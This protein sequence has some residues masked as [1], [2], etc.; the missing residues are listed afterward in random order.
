MSHSAPTSSR[1]G[2]P[3]PSLLDRAIAAVAPGYAR[4]RMEERGALAASGFYGLPSG[5]GYVGA[6]TRE[7]SMREWY[8]SI[9]S[10]SA[11]DVTLGDLPALRDACSDLARNNPLARAAKRVNMRDVVG[12]GLWPQPRIDREFLGMTEDEERAFVEGARRWWTYFAE[13]L[14][15]PCD[16]TGQHNFRGVQSQVEAGRWERGDV[17]AVRRWMPRPGALLATKVQV[18]EADRIS[19]PDDAQDTPECTAGVQRDPLTGV[20]TGYWISNQHPRKRWSTVP[21]KWEFV[22]AR[23]EQTGMPLA[24]LVYDAERPEQSRGVPE[25]APVIEAIH[26]LGEYGRGEVGAA[27]ADAFAVFAYTS[28]DLDD[29]EGGGPEEGGGAGEDEMGAIPL[30]A[31]T[32]MKLRPG[33]DFKSRAPSRP[34]TAF[35]AFTTSFSRFVG[36]ALGIPYEILLHHFT[37]SYSASR[38]AM[39]T[40]WRA[41]LVR[42]TL[43]AERLCQPFYALVIAECVARGYLAAPGF[44]TDPLRRAAYLECVWQGDVMPEIDQLKAALAAEKRIRIPLST[45]EEETLAATGGDYERNMRQRA[46]EETLRAALNLP[47][48]DPADAAV[49]NAAVAASLADT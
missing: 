48:M 27:V 9:A 14:E 19:N 35:E 5:G 47:P 46:K 29:T 49:G 25:L 7:P 42:R 28:T 8:K 17:L 11:D 20:P 45:V 40:F 4:R 41:V 13:N 44:F 34:N 22:P 1:P 31:M 15:H 6:R 26:Q 16:S 3:P 2:T 37:A 21:R 30:R 36:A 23:G 32:T 38:A 12:T 18:V 39:V 10:G 24:T 33:E 43:L